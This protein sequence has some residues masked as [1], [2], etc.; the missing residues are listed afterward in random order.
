MIFDIFLNCRISIAKLVFLFLNSE[1]YT[2][3]QNAVMVKLAQTKYV[4]IEI[5][6]LVVRMP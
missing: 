5:H 6:E 4:T 2:S 3:Y 1:K